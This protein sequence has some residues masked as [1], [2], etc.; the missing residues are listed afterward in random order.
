MPRLVYLA[1]QS[2]GRHYSLSELDR[3]MGAIYL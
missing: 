3:R 2:E 1:A